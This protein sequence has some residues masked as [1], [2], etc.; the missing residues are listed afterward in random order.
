[1][2]CVWQLLYQVCLYWSQ[3]LPFMWYVSEVVLK[4]SQYRWKEWAS[5]TDNTTTPHSSLQK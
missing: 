5:N 4:K 1:V 2:G 3:Y